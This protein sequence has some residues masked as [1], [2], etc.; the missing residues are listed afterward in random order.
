MPLE[1]AEISKEL[2]QQRRI[3]YP[4]RR[5]VALYKN[6]IWALDLIDFSHKDISYDNSGYNYILCVIDVFSKYAW[7]VALKNKTADTVTN[8]LKEIMKKSK[9]EPAFLWADR[10]G[11]FYN[12]KLKSFLQEKGITLY[13]TY[14][15]SKVVVAERFI[16]TL[17]NWIWRYFTAKH[18]RDWVSFLDDLNDYYNHQ[19]HRSIKMKPVDA[20]KP[21]NHDAVFQN[22]YGEY[23]DTLANAEPQQPK[24][25]VGDIVR[26][27]RT[28][29]SFEKGYHDNFTRQTF[30]VDEVLPTQPPTYRLKDMLNKA[31]EGSF[32]EE[33]LL[34]TKEPD[35]YEIDEILKERTVKGKK[36]V[37]V[38]WLGW[39]SKFN[40]WIDADTIKDIH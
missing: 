35:F 39:S 13:S 28:K 9:T 33:E 19:K 14:S 8:A 17:K 27:S 30:K 15:E 21:E 4:R 25:H 6:Q 7:L 34:K 12:D 31:Y 3:N 16:R 2:H 26:L 10:G 29:G 18:T 22:L 5:V 36:Q 40:S 24:F 32:Y 23:F 37:L 11:E 20:I 38:K 1:L